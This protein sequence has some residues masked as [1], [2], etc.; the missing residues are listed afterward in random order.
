MKTLRACCQQTKASGFSLTE[1]L[2]AVAVLGIFACASLFIYGSQQ[3]GTEAAAVAR[4]LAAWLGEIAMAPEERNV[5]CTVTLQPGVNLA[6][7]AA[8][9]S[10]TPATCSQSTPF[11]IPNGGRQS[12][13]FALSASPISWTYTRRGALTT[14]TG[15]AA[16]STS[17]DV[18]IKF[19][20]N[21]ESPLVCL[22]IS[23]TLGLLRFGS[24]NQAASTLNNCTLWSRR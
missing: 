16:S 1:M 5:A 6:R 4:E 8:V 12:T 11:R 17:T 21:Q 24:N 23:G 15:S 9:A 13:R 3:R 22:R 19:S 14:E 20:A 2:I 10:V 18:M 7:G